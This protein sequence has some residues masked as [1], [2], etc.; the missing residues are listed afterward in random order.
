MWPSIN[1]RCSGRRHSSNSSSSS[2]S[3]ICRGSLLSLPSTFYIIYTTRQVATYVGLISCKRRI[4]LQVT[5][6]SPVN[7]FIIYT[8]INWLGWAWAGR[9][10]VGLGV[11]LPPNVHLHLSWFGGCMESSVMSGKWIQTQVRRLRQHWPPFYVTIYNRSGEP[12]VH[13]T[14]L[15]THTHTH[16]YIHTHTY[17]HARTYTRHTSSLTSFSLTHTA[18]W[19][20]HWSD[21]VT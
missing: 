2:S 1:N 13:R 6:F 18:F 5:H 19:T 10:R 11:L 20:K 8:Q 9:G 12:R 16:S 4:T 15:P 14:M 7:W 3:S 21:V 17:T